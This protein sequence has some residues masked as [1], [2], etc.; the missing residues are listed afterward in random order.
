MEGEI[1]NQPHHQNLDL[2]RDLK[3]LTRSGTCFAFI[4]SGLS[5]GMGLYPSWKDLILRLCNRCSVP[6]PDSADLSNAETLMDLADEALASDAPTYH[7]VLAETF[8][9]LPPTTRRT[10][11]LLMQLPFK[12][13]V[14]TNFDPLLAD[15]CRLSPGRCSDVRVYPSLEAD[16]SERRVFYMHGYVP[17]GADPIDHRL[18]L[19]KTQF[20]YAYGSTTLR[21][22]LEQ[23]LTY[24]P[25]V[26][27]GARLREPSLH[28]V[29][30]FCRS[31]REDIARH[32]SATPRP[33]YILLPNLYL[34]AGGKSNET[35][36]EAESSENESFGAYD[37]RVVRYDNEN[38]THSMIDKYLTDWARLPP[39]PLRS[40]FE[41]D[42]SP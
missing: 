16:F 5:T 31:T 28:R 12:G 32:F 9:T 13:Y 18:V 33:R 3:R 6:I 21:S 41:V 42:D 29:F 27:I 2:Y 36:V 24:H 20:D 19:G 1:R 11:N 26:F 38:D 22:F 7:R 39:V 25:V 15:M 30:D 37:I 40:G 34:N 23:L 10:Y 8:G 17:D 14:T 35:D 4:G